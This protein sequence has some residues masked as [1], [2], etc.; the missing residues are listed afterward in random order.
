MVFI[1]SD[2][3]LDRDIK[4]A[5]DSAFF[6]S[7]YALTKA[8]RGFSPVEVAISLRHRFRKFFLLLINAYLSWSSRG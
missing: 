5:R 2:G 1:T 4:G 6:I 3:Y 8:M 7:I